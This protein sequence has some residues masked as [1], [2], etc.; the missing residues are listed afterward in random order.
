[1]SVHA[2]LGRAALTMLLACSPTFAQSTF[3]FSNGSAFGD[4]FAPVFDAQ[5]VPLA[6]PAYLVELW[7][8]PTPDS[9]SPALS[10]GSGTRAIVPFNSGGYFYGSS[11]ALLT[12]VSGYWAWVQVRAWQASLGPTYEEAVGRGLGG[13]GE[14][15]LL[16]AEGTSLSDLLGVPGPLTGLQSFNLRPS[17]IPEPGTVGLLA[18]GSALFARTACF[19]S[20][21]AGRPVGEPSHTIEESHEA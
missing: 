16:F 4:V 2:I 8:G 21:R 20:R 9:L 12:D 15:P 3:I 5:G 18:L 11:V 14:S 7:G 1:M 6:G 19:R 10:L 17:V 13:Y